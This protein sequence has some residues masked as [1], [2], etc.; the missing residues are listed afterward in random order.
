MGFQT[1]AGNAED[2]RV[3][4]LEGRILVAEALAFGGAARGAV[5]RVEIQHDLLALQRGKLHLLAT[6]GLGLEVADGLVD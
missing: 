6:G 3:G 5:L 1:V 4:L 2:H